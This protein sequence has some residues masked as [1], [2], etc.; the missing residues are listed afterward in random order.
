MQ[1]ISLIPVSLL[2]LVIFTLAILSMQFALGQR[3]YVNTNDMVFELTYSNG[4]CQLEKIPI[5]CDLSASRTIYSIAIYRDTL[6]Y[7][8]GR[9]LFRVVPGKPG[10]CERIAIL[11]GNG[12]TYNCMAADRYG[13]VFLI[14]YNSKTLYRYDPIAKRLDTLGQVPSAPAGDLMFFKGKLLYA[15]AADG[16]YEIDIDQPERSIQYMPTP[17][18]S[19]YGLLSFPFDCNGNKVYG[20]SLHAGGT[21]TDL[22]ELDLDKKI[23]LSRFSTLP[24]GLYDAA[25]SV[26]NGNTNGITIDSIEL[27]LAKC[28]STHGADAR[29]IAFTAVP[30]TLKYTMDGVL[31]NEDGKFTHLKEGRHLLNILNSKGC[32][33]DTMIMVSTIKDPKPLIDIIKDDP[34]CTA[35]SGKIKLEI[36]GNESPYKINFNNE[37]FSTLNVYDRLNAGKYPITIRNKNY[38]SWDTFAVI[39]SGC[40][41]LFMPNAFTPNGDGKNEFIRPVFGVSVADVRFTIY[42]RFGQKIFES[43]GPTNGWDGSIGGNKQPSGSFAYTIS[44][45]NAAGFK[46]SMKGTVMLIR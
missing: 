17:G 28:N 10:G 44:Y 21:S 43:I 12:A 2:R 18:Y 5:L 42:N 15:T 24:Y 3:I 29:F 27:N 41:N 13:K 31:L 23:I 11:P 7:N 39:K 4:Q 40:D 1:S 8:S 37:G 35:L 22:I 26:D 20:V 16:I 45:K 36:N 14:E 34:D 19:F 32:S 46:K 6:Y 38:C 33:L 30:G 25:S 9:N